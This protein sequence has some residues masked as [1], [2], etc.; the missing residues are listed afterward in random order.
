MPHTAELTVS[1]ISTPID[2]QDVLG[3]VVFQSINL[4]LTNSAFCV[5]WRYFRQSRIF[6][7]DVNQ[8]VFWGWFLSPVAAELWALTFLWQSLKNMHW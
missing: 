1:S 5:S 2:G 3:R 6:T 7:G 8:R 4:S